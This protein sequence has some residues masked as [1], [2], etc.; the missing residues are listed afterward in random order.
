MTS[1]QMEL[2]EKANLEMYMHNNLDSCLD[3]IMGLYD[4]IPKF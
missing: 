3:A 2:R 1:K 4:R